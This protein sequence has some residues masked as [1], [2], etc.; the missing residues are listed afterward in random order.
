MPPGVPLLFVVQVPLDIYESSG[1]KKV[2]YLTP[3][4]PQIVVPLA[5]IGLGVQNTVS[6]SPDDQ[7]VLVCEKSSQV[8]PIPF[9]PGFG[10]RRKVN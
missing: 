8:F 2:V 4:L 9:N 1:P 3:P 5:G 7:V 10:F 6:V